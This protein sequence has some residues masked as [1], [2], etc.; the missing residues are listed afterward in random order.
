MEIFWRQRAK[1]HWTEDGDRNTKFFHRVASVRRKFNAMQNI[2]MDGKPH[3][4]DSSVKGVIV[5][6][7][8]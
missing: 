2:V 7:Y 4:E 6:F 1:Q 5:H 3:V 8:E